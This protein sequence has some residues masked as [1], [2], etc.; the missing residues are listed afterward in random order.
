MVAT[1]K[2]SGLAGWP[3]FACAGPLVGSLTTL[4]GNVG[5]RTVAAQ[6]TRS[7]NVNSAMPSFIRFLRE[8]LECARVYA[9]GVN[10]E[11]S[12]QIPARQPARCDAH[13]RAACF[14]ISQ[15]L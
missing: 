11:T 6:R 13:G 8:C 7:P 9:A 14:N 1:V 12:V 4:G 2:S 15:R 3:S 10:L 5:L